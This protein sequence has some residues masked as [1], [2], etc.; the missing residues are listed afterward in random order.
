METPAKRRRALLESNPR[1]NNWLELIAWPDGELTIKSFPS[2]CFESHAI[3][4]LCLRKLMGGVGSPC[5]GLVQT[6]VF[7]QV[8]YMPGGEA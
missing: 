3:V 7:Y 6:P 4:S 2:G 8:R 1:R 5:G